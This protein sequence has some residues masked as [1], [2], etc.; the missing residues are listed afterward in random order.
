MKTPAA[1]GSAITKPTPVKARPSRS[2]GRVVWRSRV[3][4]SLMP[5][6]LLKSGFEVGEHRLGVL[7]LDLTRERA[8]FH[9]ALVGRRDR[10]RP[11]GP[12]HRADHREAAHHGGELQ[13]RS[14]ATLRHFL[15]VHMDEDADDAERDRD[16]RHDDG[17]HEVARVD[18]QPEAI[19]QR[20]P[21]DAHGGGDEQQHTPPSLPEAFE[22]WDATIADR[23][24]RGAR[25]FVIVG[26]VLIRQRRS[27]RIRGPPRRARRPR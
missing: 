23:R 21:E 27:L 19:G 7:P 12:H 1:S 20:E 9:R 26:G 14:A 5:K 6:V 22:Q 16:E 8:E 17:E 15:D 13:R 4:Q 24:R 11:A 2:A 25:V 10:E 18:V 3:A